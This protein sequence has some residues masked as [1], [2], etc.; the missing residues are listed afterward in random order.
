MASSFWP[1]KMAG[2][3]FI[4]MEKMGGLRTCYV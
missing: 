3:P 2:I 4:E 1:E